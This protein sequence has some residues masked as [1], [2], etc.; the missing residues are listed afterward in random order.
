MHEVYRIMIL[1]LL[2]MI[3]MVAVAGPTVMVKNSVGSGIVESTMSNR[4][5]LVCGILVKESDVVCWT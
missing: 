1:P 4:M 5:Q 2:S 3:V